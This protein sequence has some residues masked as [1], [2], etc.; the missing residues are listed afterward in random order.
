MTERYVD[1]L[2]SR[3][4]ETVS[5]TATVRDAA[6]TMTERDVGAV[7]VVDGE[8]GIE[9]VLTTTDLA[10]LIGRGESSES[11]VAEFMR[12]PVITTTRDTPVHEVAGTMMDNLIHHVPVVDGEEVVGIITT[13]DLTAHLARS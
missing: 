13:L 11:A 10:R 9:G 5:P 12:T 2:M 4:V 7:V 3:P 8:G 6:R 1:Q